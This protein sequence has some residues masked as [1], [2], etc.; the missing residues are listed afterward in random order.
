MFKIFISQPMRGLDDATIEAHRNA[1]IEYLEKTYPGCEIVDSFFKGD[2]NLKLDDHARLEL[3]GKSIIKLSTADAI[4]MCNG[5]RDK[6]GC[7]I[8]HECAARYG[9][10]VIYEDQISGTYAGN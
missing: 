6:N 10:K 1:V 5:W 9:L 2:P 8:E 7:F 3:L 4:F